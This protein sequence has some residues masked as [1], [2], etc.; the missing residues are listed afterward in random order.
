MLQ[1]IAFSAREAMAVGTSFYLGA[2]FFGVVMILLRKPY[3]RA[4]MFALLAAGFTFQ[5]LGLNLRGAEIKGCP[6]GNIFEI[7]LLYTS[8]SPRD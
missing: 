3:P 2:L 8:P 1:E 4:I 5:T 7:C 6:L